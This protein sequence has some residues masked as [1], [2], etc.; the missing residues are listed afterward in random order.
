[1]TTLTRSEILRLFI[2]VDISAEKLSTLSHV[3]Q[4]LRKSHVHGIRLVAD[5]NIHLT[6][7]FLG[8]TVRN[9]LPRLIAT[10]EELGTQISPFTVRLGNFGGFP[11]LKQPHIL[12]VGLADMAQS[13]TA[14]AHLVE[15]ACQSI[16]F[17]RATQPF[18]P[19]LTLARMS[20]TSS[21]KD[22]KNASETLLS[23][24]WEPSTRI[25]IFSISLIES[26]LTPQGPIYRSLH[27]V[28][29]SLMPNTP[30]SQDADG[31]IRC[32]LVV[33][34]SGAVS[35]ITKSSRLIQAV[36]CLR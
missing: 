35:T 18:I 23:L 14:L 25:P 33:V 5:Q 24:Q 27:S 10:L 16:G 30:L 11:D 6:P 32:G 31:N 17:Q 7:K 22:R 13:V 3:M 21:S 29:L 4:S 2:A 9:Q 12:W 1:M 20:A 15:D 26:T 8:D 19:H 36:S 28:P 34:S